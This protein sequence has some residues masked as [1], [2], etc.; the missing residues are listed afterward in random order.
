MKEF[1][2]EILNFLGLAFWVEIITDNPQCTYYF[3]PFFQ[4]KAATASTQGYLD[5]LK[6]EGAAG[7]KVTVKRCRPGELTI[8]DEYDVKKTKNIIPKFS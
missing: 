4:E 7:I 2:I 3:G 5:D 8:F 1:F 6:Q